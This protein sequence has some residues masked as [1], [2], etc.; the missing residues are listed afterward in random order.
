[1]SLT[2]SFE[3]FVVAVNFF[4]NFIVISA[5]FAS[6]FILMFTVD[7]CFSINFNHGKGGLPIFFFVCCLFLLR[8]IFA[9]V[10]FFSCIRWPSQLSHLLLIVLLHGW[11]PVFLRSSSLLIFF[12]HLIFQ[13][14]KMAQPIE[15]SPSDCFTP[16]LG[17]RFST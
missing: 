10:L 12:G 13:L 2:I 7:S 16:W 5:V 9:G 3:S 11:D 15:S 17:S 6:M 8:T 4:K 1:M 14:Y